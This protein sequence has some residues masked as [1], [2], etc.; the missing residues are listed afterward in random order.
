YPPDKPHE[1]FRFQVLEDQ[2]D[3]YDAH[4]ASWALWTYKDIG[5]QGALHVDPT[6]EYLRH[7]A[8]IRELKAQLGTD[9]WGGT[10][11]GVR[12]ILDP[13]DAVMGREFPD[14]E[15]YPSGRRQHVFRLV[16]HILLA[17]PLAARFAALFAGATPGRARHLADSFSFETTLQRDRLVD[18]LRRRVGSP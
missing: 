3:I 6:S 14:Y 8:A 2:L 15:P 10:D 11:L 13:I 9:S 7:I 18:I 5:L 4:G 12:D 16:P 1:E 17:A